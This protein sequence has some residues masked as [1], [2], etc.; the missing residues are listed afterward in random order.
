MKS[1]FALALLAAV[2]SAGSPFTLED[3][4]RYAQYVAQHNKRNADTLDE[5]LRREG[6]W[7]N[8]DNF[9]NLNNEDAK[10]K[11]KKTGYLNSYGHNDFSDMDQA[12]KEG[13]LNPLEDGYGD[14]NTEDSPDD[15]RREL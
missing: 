5:Y 11:A 1:T 6:N 14:E 13:Y 12:E 9:I 10:E 8:T 3:D 4:R 2:A 15:G 7:K